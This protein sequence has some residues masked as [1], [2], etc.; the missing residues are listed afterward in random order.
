MILSDLPFDQNHNLLLAPKQPSIPTSQAA[1]TQL[2]QPLDLGKLIY[3]I[4]DQMRST[5]IVNDVLHTTAEQL[6]AALQVSGCLVYRSAWELS[7]VGCVSPPQ[8]SQEVLIR[9][10]HS[11]CQFY[12]QTLVQG[13]PVVLSQIDSQ[14]STDLQ[15]LAK[16]SNI[17][18]LLIFP[19]L[20]QQ[21]YLG[22]ISLYQF[23][24]ERQWMPDELNF[25]DAIAH[26]CAVAIHQCEL[27]QQA[28]QEAAYYQR[29]EAAFLDNTCD[30][31]EILQ[32]FPD[33]YLRL[34]AQ[35]TILSYYTGDR[36]DA[37]LEPNIFLK[38]SLQNTLPLDIWHQWHQAILQVI[39]TNLLVTIHYSL[40]F[41]RNAKDFEARLL[42]SSE[43]QIFAIIRDITKEKQAEKILQVAKNEL[44]IKVC[45]RTIELENINQRLQQ[46]ICERIST[47]ALLAGQNQILE[48]IAT[49]SSL[50]NILHFITQFVEEQS[51]QALCSILLLDSHT[52]NLH[53]CIAP[54]LT[55][56]CKQ[57][58]LGVMLQSNLNFS[59]ITADYQQSII[60]YDLVSDLRWQPYKELVL[61]QGLHTCWSTPIL[62]ANG[63]VQG[64]FILYYRTPHSP[65]AH[66]QKLV[67]LCT[68]LIGIANERKQTQE[69]LQQSEEKF[70]NLVEQT[71][72]WVWEMDQNGVFTYVNSQLGRILGYKPHEILGKTYFELMSLDQAKRVATVL[73]YFT[74]HQEPF[75]NLEQTL[76]HKKGY[77][78]VFE[79][80]GTP[81]FDSLGQLK[82]YRGIGRDI[83]ERK[84]VEREIRK[85]LS[86]EKELNE[87]KSRFVSMTSHEFRT[88]LSTILSS[89]ELL[90]HY[91]EKLTAEKKIRHLH[92]I[93]TAVH[94]MT[95]MLNDVLVIGKA[96]AGK[97]ECN[98][99]PLD[100]SQFC[101]D[102]VEELQ[103]SADGSHTIC[104]IETRNEV[105]N[106]N[107]P[108]SSRKSQPYLDEKLLRHIL[109]NLLSNA[110]KYSPASS[111]VQFE[112]IYQHD[113]AIFKIQ[114]SGIGI[115]PADQKQLFN[116]F[117]RATNVGTI[118]G[119]GL[120]LAVV[121]KC[122]ELQGGTIMVESDIGV[123]T[124]FKV[125]LPLKY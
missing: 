40:S 123:G 93:Q 46:E 6:H 37:F 45:E 42:P 32:A 92:R 3:S 105:E 81:V 15:A 110:I 38:K 120:G 14:L 29:T 66:E 76:I 43:N 54:N 5:L 59:E 80:S 87:L 122:V 85:A 16:D 71:N 2:E 83:T 27:Y 10:R 109:N 13:Q 61:T 79:T 70:R 77:A 102:L 116:S 75:K 118:P 50:L 96:E 100:L 114:D 36:P 121:K 53:Y 62:A 97:L 88:P 86:K 25:V 23:E 69:S 44:E 64:I 72:D 84:Q 115:P 67:A 98:P 99:K 91:S 90:E 52:P 1:S 73:D 41:S 119:T 11:F 21:S 107:K 78:V 35:G 60:V 57:A 101:R 111:L 113:E 51:A 33:L 20:Y 4:V 31:L 55:E 8:V 9:L 124:L 7:A 117:H 103:L 12:S 17:R 56:E 30:F 47:E 104:F 19:L 58:T 112:L 82:G 18:S 22:E 49:G 34:D 74:S 106:P 39:E 28:K 89:A 94:H 48:L 65:N 95:Q 125:V 108:V 63:K 26:Q 68:H 24:L